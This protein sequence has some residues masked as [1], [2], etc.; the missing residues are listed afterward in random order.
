MHENV[1]KRIDDFK[2]EVKSNGSNIKELFEIHEEIYFKK[3]Y[4]EIDETHNHLIKKVRDI[5][6]NERSKINESFM[7]QNISFKTK[8]KKLEDAKIGYGMYVFTNEE[9]E[10]YIFGDTHSDYISI[11]LALYE[12]GELNRDKRIIFLGDYTDRGYSHLEEIGLILML[13]YIYP[14]SIY[15]LRG[16]HDTG[17]ITKENEPK[18]GVGKQDNTDYF[19]FYIWDL[20]KENKVSKQFVLNHLK[21]FEELCINAMLDFEDKKIMAVHGGIPRPDLE[22]ENYYWYLNRLSDI[23]D[24]ELKDSNG[25]TSVYSMLWSDPKEEIMR[26]DKGRFG[27]TEAHFDAFKSHIGFDIMIRGHEA[28]EEGYREF[29]GGKILNIFSSGKQSMT[30]AYEAVEAKY[31]KVTKKKG[32]E[33]FT[34]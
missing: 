31:L 6:S 13:K 21:F 25:K 15:L 23:Y 7:E 4:L 29:Y 28:P 20:Y 22:K 24:D 32:V 9:A 14:E 10:Y 2:Q 34:I 16:N 3:N 12:I 27:F 1:K 33:V 30:S 8:D 11:K 19:L 18:L 5:M 17:S 26:W